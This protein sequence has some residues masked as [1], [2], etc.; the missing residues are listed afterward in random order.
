MILIHFNLLYKAEKPSVCPHFSSSHVLF[1]GLRIDQRWTCTKPKLCPLA[2]FS[3]FLKDLRAVF[4]PRVS[5]VYPCQLKWPSFSV[6]LNNE[7]T[8]DLLQR[9]L[10]QHTI[11]HM[12]QQ[13]MSNKIIQTGN[14]WTIRSLSYVCF[15][16]GMYADDRIEW[17]AHVY[18][19]LSNT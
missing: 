11:A 17:H 13:S 1:C 5:K 19:S 12:N 14:Q 7:V 3:S 6:A 18:S 4:F 10:R 9:Y 2:S 16:T 15:Y 8:A